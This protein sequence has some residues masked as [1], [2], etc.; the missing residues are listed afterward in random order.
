[1]DFD[2]VL[3]KELAI[4]G[5]F[6]F[7]FVFFNRL[8]NTCFLQNFVNDRIRTADICIGSNC[9]AN[10]ATTIDQVQQ[11]NLNKLLAI[12]NPEIFQIGIP[13]Q[14]MGGNH[15]DDVT[16]D[17]VSTATASSGPASCD[18]FSEIHLNEL[19]KLEKQLESSEA[20]K[21]QLS[22]TLK[23]TRDSL[24]KTKGELTSQQVSGN[25]LY[26]WLVS[27]VCRSLWNENQFFKGSFTLVFLLSVFENVTPCGTFSKAGYVLI[28][29]LKTCHPAV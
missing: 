20:D 26:C 2:C 6:F 21:S 8:Q 5:L 25:S 14:V 7:I 27:S 12:S 15:A 23:E 16:M 17:P 10:W 13:H 9:S 24:E 19:Q 29:V 4:P 1:M 3:F 11:S 18:L 22:L 28:L